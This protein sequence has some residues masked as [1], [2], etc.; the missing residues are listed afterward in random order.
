VAGPIDLPGVNVATVETPRGAFPEA[1]A[2]LP[3]AWHARGVF[4]IA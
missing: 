4:W 3:F 1:A 2:P